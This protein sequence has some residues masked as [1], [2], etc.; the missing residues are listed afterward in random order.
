MAGLPLTGRQATGIDWPAAD[1]GDV[2]EGHEAV[3]D[4]Q[5]DLAQAVFA[6]EGAIDFDSDLFGIGLDDAGRRHRVLL[7]QGGDDL[8]DIEIERGQLVGLE[9]NG[10][11]FGLDA[12]QFDLAHIGHIHE[13]GAHLVD[14]LTDFP[15]AEAFVLEAVDDAVGV[16]EFVI[17]EGAAHAF[18]ELGR[19]VRHLLA[20]LIPGVRNG[21]GRSVVAQID[22]DDRFPGSGVALDE[23]EMRRF[24]ELLLDGVGE[25]VGGLLRRRARPGGRDHHGLDGEGRI[26]P[27]ERLRKLNVPAITVRIIMKMTSDWFSS[28]Q[29]DRL[30]PGFSS[31][32]DITGALPRDERSGRAAAC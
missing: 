12:E 2:G 4:A 26:F 23:I 19:E 30:K 10:D 32:E 1:V 6:G 3:V 11:L 13:A 5:H 29:R 22:E 25:E 14:A 21:I 17:E 7:L 9:G 20:H 8:V 18:G 31:V 24:L 28:A 27:R 16:G 15:G